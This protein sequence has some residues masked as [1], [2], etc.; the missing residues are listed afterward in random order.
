METHK[1]GRAK[2]VMESNVFGG[3]ATSVIEMLTLDEQ[4]KLKL[5]NCGAISKPKVE[6]DYNHIASKVKDAINR[7]ISQF[8]YQSTLQQPSQS[9]SV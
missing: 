5:V 6:K 4:V 1:V 9:K 2:Q 3:V 8:D 7:P